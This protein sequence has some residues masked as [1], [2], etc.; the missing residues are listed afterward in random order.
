MKIRIGLFTV[1]A[2]GSF[3][4]KTYVL[5]LSWNLK[6]FAFASRFFLSKP[7]NLSGPF[8]G[9]RH[10][11]AAAFLYDGCNKKVKLKCALRQQMAH[12]ILRVRSG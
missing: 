1:K 9:V 8:F 10:I 7:A 12:S 11:L 6:M 3:I 4:S 5:N 2:A